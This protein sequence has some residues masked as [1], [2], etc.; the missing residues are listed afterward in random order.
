LQEQ[1]WLI[2]GSTPNDIDNTLQAIDAFWFVHG[3]GSKDGGSYSWRRSVI[4]VRADLTVRIDPQDNLVH[5]ARKDPPLNY[6]NGVT[7]IQTGGQPAG[8]PQPEIPL[9]S[10]L[11]QWSPTLTGSFEWPYQ[12]LVE[13]NLGGKLYKWKMP[14]RGVPDWST[15][16]QKGWLW[17][18]DGSHYVASWH[19]KIDFV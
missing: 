2:F 5:L 11:T 3:D 4:N 1:T 12:R 15:A 13:F 16:L 10:G 17:E 7:G 14:N 19:W 6:Q 8:Y 9:L 18:A